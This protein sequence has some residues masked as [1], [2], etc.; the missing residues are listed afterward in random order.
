MND[1][2]AR[3]NIGCHI[4]HSAD[5]TMTSGSF[6]RSQFDSERYDTDNMHYTSAANLTGTV[7][8][9]ASSTTVTG[10][11][12]LFT[13]EL[14]VGQ[15]IS[16]PGT[17]AEP[18]VVTAIASD[19]SLTV[20]TAFANSASGQTAARLNNG[21]VFRTPGVYAICANASLT[22]N[23]T[24]E[25]LLR[26]TANDA[27]TAAS[28]T[29]IVNDFQMGPAG[30]YDNTVLKALVFYKFA[31]WDWICANFFNDSGNN[32]LKVTAQANFSPFL[33]AHYLSEG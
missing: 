11:S 21:I 19:T 26:V 10:S 31:Q 29:I 13:S 20:Q 5:Q 18:R 14:S 17:A 3:P 30:A 12:T 32:T 8:K 6:L 22:A 4:Y 24:N 2:P 27:T 7:S 23:A 9:T 16:V 15:M 1:W 33:A 28:G 25:R